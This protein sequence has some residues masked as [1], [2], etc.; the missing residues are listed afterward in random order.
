MIGIT[1]ATCGADNIALYVPYFTTVNLSLLPMIF[2]IFIFIL[3]FSIF[4]AQRVTKIKIIY[5][6]LERFGD[7]A[8]LFIY[9][10]LGIYVMFSAGTIQHFLN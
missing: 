7:K 2:I 9:V 10:I 6:I 5:Q 3:S 1:I 8:Q 4:L